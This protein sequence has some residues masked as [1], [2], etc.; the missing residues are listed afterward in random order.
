MKNYYEILEVHP[1]ASSEVIEKAY[2]VLVMKNHPDVVGEENSKI[3]EINEAYDILSNNFLRKQYDLELENN[4]LRNQNREYT[5][6][7]M[8]S[9]R[10]KNIRKYNNNNNQKIETQSRPKVGTLGSMFEIVKLINPFSK[11]RRINREKKDAETIKKD[12]LALII[13]IFVIIL[14]GVIAW[15]VPFTN[16]FMRE[17]TVENPLLSWLFK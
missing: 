17:L 14:L 1:K 6:N 4:M 15:F 9:N 10:K 2:K 3:A 11:E 12:R 13:T 7:T 8:A 5:E 16:Q